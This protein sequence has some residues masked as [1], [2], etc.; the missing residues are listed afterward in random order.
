MTEYQNCWEHEKCGREP[1]GK[2]ADR[3][4]ICPAATEARLN[5]VHGGINGGRACW[6]VAGTLCQ[7]KVQGVFAQKYATCQNCAFYK[8]VQRENFRDFQVSVAL[9]QRL[10]KP[11]PG[12]SRQ[13]SVPTP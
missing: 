12:F 10:K 9:L 4:G 7:G 3:L 2:N 11:E 8:K 1:N 13:P 6:V 5:G